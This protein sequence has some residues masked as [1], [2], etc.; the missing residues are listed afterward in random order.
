MWCIPIIPTIYVVSVQA[1]VL[2]SALIMLQARDSITSHTIVFSLS[3]HSLPV[4]AQQQSSLS[5]NRAGT[6][7]ALVPRQDMYSFSEIPQ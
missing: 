7:S 2:D 4:C 3:Q 5:S 6:L 1:T